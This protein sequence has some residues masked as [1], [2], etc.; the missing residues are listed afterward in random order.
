MSTLITGIGTL[1]TNDPHVQDGY[2]D[3]HP[4]PGV[5]EASTAAPAGPVNGHIVSHDADPLGQLH[6]A[7]VV[8]EEGSNRLGGACRSCSGCR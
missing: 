3:G 7:A 8:I 1:V 2:D 5:D 6:G 4:G